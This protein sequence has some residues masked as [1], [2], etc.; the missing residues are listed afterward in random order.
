MFL[1]RIIVSFSELR[2]QIAHQRVEPDIVGRV[3]QL[4]GESDLIGALAH[5]LRFGFRQSVVENEVGHPK[6]VAAFMCQR[7]VQVGVSGNGVFATCRPVSHGCL[8]QVKAR[9]AF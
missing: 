1:V 5:A 8:R 7:S 2:V 3:A 9:Y 4:G 6:P